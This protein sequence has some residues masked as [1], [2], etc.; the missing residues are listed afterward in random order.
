MAGVSLLRTYPS[1]VGSLL[2]DNIHGKL[3]AIKQSQ[4]RKSM[5]KLH[6]NAFGGPDPLG[7]RI[8]A[9]PQT[10]SRNVGHFYSDGEQRRG[11]LIRKGKHTSK[12]DGREGRKERRDG[13][14]EGGNCPPPSQGE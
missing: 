5:P 13:K 14:G 8:C 3:L 10:P 9:L 11:L 6:R 2:I 12:G 4:G 1:S 7:M